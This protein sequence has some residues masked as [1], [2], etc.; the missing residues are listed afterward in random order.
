MKAEKDR[1]YLNE[2][3]KGETTCVEESIEYNFKLDT[4]GV[5]GKPFNIVPIES[6]FRRFTTRL[7]R[8]FYFDW[9]IISMIFLNCI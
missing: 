4:I 2:R 1:R 3:L 7:L 9:F 5:E 8:N 6:C